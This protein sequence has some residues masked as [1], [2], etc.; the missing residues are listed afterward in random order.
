[1][2]VVRPD[3]EL[4]SKEKQEAIVKAVL[5]NSDANIGDITPLGKKHLAYPIKKYTEGSYLL[6]HLDANAVVVGEFEKHVRLGT[7]VLRYL[8]LAKS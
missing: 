3:V 2:L 6:A 8:L 7:D 4:D 5:G 1:M